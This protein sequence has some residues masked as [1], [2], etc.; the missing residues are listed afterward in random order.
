MA[1]DL[2]GAGRTRLDVATVEL[3]ENCQQLVMIPPGV[4]VG[5]VSCSESVVIHYYSTADYDSTSERGFRWN[6]PM[7]QGRI[8][9][10]DPTISS[11]DG[12][13]P[14]LTLSDIAGLKFD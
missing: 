11:K 10:I 3:Q 9:F 8:P 4:A 7:L 14:D 6:D 13:W 1:V 2:R 12:S 5:Y